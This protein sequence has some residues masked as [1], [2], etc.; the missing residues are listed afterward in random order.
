MPCLT[1]EAR[2]EQ[3]PAWINGQG[4]E[5][6]QKVL[7]DGVAKELERVYPGCVKNVVQIST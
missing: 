7:W 5:Q 2:R 4:A 3:V 1:N 6:Y